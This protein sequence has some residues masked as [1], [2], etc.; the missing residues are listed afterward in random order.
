MFEIWSVKRVTTQVHYLPFIPYEM[1]RG[2]TTRQV[3]DLVHDR[4]TSYI[5][6]LMK[7]QG[8]DIT[9]VSENG[10]KMLEQNIQADHIYATVLQHKFGR[11][12]QNEYQRQLVIL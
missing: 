11:G 2:M 6:Q 8:R 5:D 9:V 3:S 4:I 1:Y 7:K 10:L 12:F